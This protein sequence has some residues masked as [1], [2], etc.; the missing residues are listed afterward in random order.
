MKLY[1][2]IIMIFGLPG[3]GKSYFARHL[4]Q[5]IG[6]GYLNTD[7]IREELD[8]KGIYDEKTKQLVY[9]RLVEKAS[10]Q[11][12]K[13]LDVIVDGTFHKQKRRDIFVG[14]AEKKNREINFIEIR[15][16]EKTIRKRLKETR[17]HSE[18]DYEVYKQIKKEFESE[19]RSHL[20]LWSD[21]QNT[22]ELITKAKNYIYGYQPG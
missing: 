10:E 11:M 5:D 21:S 15:A 9:D 19:Y 16:S 20:I 4:Q 14:I 22:V 7:M 1:T 2:M 18:A 17:K 12:D 6:A 8:L 3:S 13:G